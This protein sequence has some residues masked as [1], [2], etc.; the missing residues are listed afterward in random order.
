M[1]LKMIRISK[2]FTQTQ[3]AKNLFVTQRCLSNWE[4]GTR[5]PPISILPKLA[6]LLH[7]SIEQLVYAIIE[8]KQTNL[9]NSEVQS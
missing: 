1:T 9:H 3:V 8:T 6:E 2:K 4:N 7:I 5:E